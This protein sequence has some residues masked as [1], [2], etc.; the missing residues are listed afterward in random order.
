MDPKLVESCRFGR[1]NPAHAVSVGHG[2]TCAP[3]AGRR[4]PRRVAA[5]DDPHGDV[6]A[7]ERLS[8]VEPGLDALSASGPLRGTQTA[9]RS[10]PGE[11][12]DAPLP[13]RA[14]AAFLLSAAA[15]LPSICRRSCTVY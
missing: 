7:G 4:H 2:S 6:H 14:P 10:V 1:T 13:S 12:L 9:R 8:A 11:V 3:L 5:V 15:A